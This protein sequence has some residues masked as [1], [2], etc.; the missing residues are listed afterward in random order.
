M[1]LRFLLDTSAIAEPMKKAPDEAVVAKIEAHAHE[2]AIAAP[3]W[4]ELRY[5]C[6]LLPSGK[7][8]S[9]LEAY[10][11]EVVYPA[12]PILPYD[13]VA[14]AWHADERARLDGEGTP[15]PFVDG[16]IAA[17]AAI[18]DLILVTANVRDFQ[19]FQ[20]LTIES[21]ASRKRRAS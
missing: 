8:R 12:F 19:R 11:R 6:R 15:A 14:A 2:S 4:H 9:A 21:W 18:N 16:Q 10:L 5:G 17:I 3:G 1:T 13:A 7:R 20:G